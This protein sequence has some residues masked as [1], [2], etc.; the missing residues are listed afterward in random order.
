[1]KTKKSHLCKKTLIECTFL[2]LMQ[3]MCRKA[4]FS[5]C[6]LVVKKLYSIDP[7]HEGLAFRYFIILTMIH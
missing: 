4:V 5:D 7:Q 3:N 2:N 1:M 6:Q